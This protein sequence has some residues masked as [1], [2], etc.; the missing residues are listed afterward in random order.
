MSVILSEVKGFTPVIDVVANELGFITAGVY[1]IV[2]RHC[3]MDSHVCRASAE[4][5]AAMLDVSV[6]T[7]R[8]HIRKLVEAGY[9]IDD[10]PDRRNAPH[11]YR[12]AGKVQIDGLIQAK[13]VTQ[14]EQAEDVCQPEVTQKEQAVTH[15]GQPRLPT[16][17]NEDT[18]TNE[19]SISPPDGR[20]WFLSLASLCVADLSVATKAQTGLLGQSSKKLKDAGVTPEQIDAFG[21]WWYEND[22][23]GK[24]GQPPTPSQ[25]RS[26]WGK[27]IKSGA[28]GGRRVVKIGR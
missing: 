8:R 20:A 16:E 21:S 27:F 18:D 22:W 5:L 14:K 19:D 11:V 28:G 15:R 1:G 4:T 9:I 7:I 3:Q 2:W 25:V 24:T 17:S 6:N 23:R 12:D 26:E 13:E 10:T